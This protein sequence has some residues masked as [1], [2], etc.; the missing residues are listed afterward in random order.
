MHEDDDANDM[1]CKQ[2]NKMNERTNGQKHNNYI[3]TCIARKIYRPYLTWCLE[4][5]GITEGRT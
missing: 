2:I 5:I 1:K 3:R 4:Q